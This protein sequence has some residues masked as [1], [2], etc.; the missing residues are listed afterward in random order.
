MGRNFLAV[1]ASVFMLVLMLGFASAVIDLSGPS[2]L[3]LTKQGTTFTVS[4]TSGTLFDLNTSTT[5]TLTLTDSNSK[6]VVFSV[7]AN[8]ST[9]VNSVLFSVNLSSIDSGFLIDEYTGNI[10][11]NATENA[12]AN[13]DSIII[14]VTFTN[15]FCD[16]GAVNDTELE[17][18]VDIS[19]TGEGDDNAWIPLDNIEID[20][21]FENKEGSD[22]DMDDVIIELNIFETGSSSDIASDMIWFSTDDEKAEIGNIDEDEKDSHLFEFRVDPSEVNDGNHILVIKAYPKGEESE[23]CIDYSSDFDN[24]DFGTDDFLAD[25]SIDLENEQDKMVV[26]DTTSYPA[27]IDAF[28]DSNVLFEPAIYNIG[29]DDFADQ[30]KVT[31]FNQELGVNLEDVILGDFDSGDSATALFSFNVP[32]NAVEKTYTLQMETLYDYDNDDDTYDE[33]SEDVFNAYLVVKGNCEGSSTTGTGKAVVSAALESG[34]SAGEDMVVRAT[35]TNTGNNVATYIV[36]AAGYAEW[37]STASAS[38]AALTLAKGESGSVLVTLA[39]KE[40]VSGSKTFN[41]E[42]VSGNELVAQQPVSVTVQAKS[43]G[44]LTGLAIGDNAYLWGLGALNVILIV[45]II[46]VVVRVLRK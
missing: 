23:T 21:E 24:S 8:D 39:V 25:I 12:S 33:S 38:P 42:V 13:T 19:N 40:G 46:I 34:G 28:C 35:I 36:N 45:A 18:N 5:S 20:V 29:S 1:F 31:L 10:N 6:T 14:P 30:I 26:V 7:T 3:S 37:A 44:F 9:D 2:S 11:V 22:F 41:L 32:S 15:S 16:D 17:L 27:A 43:S 4:E